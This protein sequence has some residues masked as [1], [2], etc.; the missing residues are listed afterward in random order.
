M[1]VELSANELREEIAEVEKTNTDECRV[2]LKKID[3]ETAK[4]YI[5]ERGYTHTTGYWY[6]GE[7]IRYARG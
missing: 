1:I 6:D 7:K 2:T 4:R 5:F 3:A